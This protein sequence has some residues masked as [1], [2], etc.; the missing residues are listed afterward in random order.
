MGRQVVFTESR[1]LRLVTVRR[2]GTY[3]TP[4]IASS[5]CGR[6]IARGTCCTT[7]RKRNPGRPSAPS[8]RT[9]ARLGAG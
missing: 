8:D 9:G 1:D 3:R 7:S 6:P 2:G 5:P 4:I